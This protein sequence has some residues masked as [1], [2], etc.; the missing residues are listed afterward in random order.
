MFSPRWVLA[1]PAAILI[2]AAAVFRRRL[3]ALPILSLILVLGPV[4]GFCLPSPLVQQPHAG[5]ARL[6]VLTCNMH[7]Q[8]L[9]SAALHRLIDE[10]RPDL[11]ALQECSYR[12]L[13]RT[14]P[15]DR[16]QIDDTCGLIL[17]SRYPIRR[18]E[19]IGGSSM[20]TKGLVMRYELETPGGMVT[21]FSLHLATPR[22][23][24]SQF[25]EN[26]S[27]IPGDL[28]AGSELRWE[29]SKN[30][31]LAARAVR[32]PV[33]LTGDF[34]TPPESAIFHRLWQGYT[35]AFASGGWGWGYTFNHF[36]AVRIDLILA[37]PGWRCESCWVGPEVGSPHR[38]V[39]A[40]L[41]RRA[42]PVGSGPGQ[43]KEKEP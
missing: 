3:L 29:Q 9:Y 13:S 42:I 11:V 38:P 36:T 32:G 16:W 25:G 2:P 19:L 33:L 18:A 28:E 34:N 8:P 43:P 10:K 22:S 12:S 14:L 4:M 27:N 40:D 1:L 39:L 23:A 31:A 7:Y 21:F 20:G 15:R 24:L 30:L 26:N 35:D 41:I 5:E 17:A 37:G 6:R